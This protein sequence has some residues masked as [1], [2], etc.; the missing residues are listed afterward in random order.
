MSQTDVLALVATLSA[1]QADPTT[2][3]GYYLDEVEDL[4]SANWHT[5]AQPVT[6]TA[7]SDAVTLPDTMLN[8]LSF[9]YDDDVLEDVGL[10][11]LESLRIGWRNEPGRPIAFTRQGTTAKTL[12]LFPVPNLTPTPIIPLHGLPTGEDYEPGNAIAIVSEFRA[13]ALE[14]LTLPLALRVLYREY[15]RTSDHTDVNFAELCKQ[16]ADVLLG[17]LRNYGMDQSGNFN[18]GP[19]DGTARQS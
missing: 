8:L 15:S 5:T 10:R 7:G 13:D 17:L 1:N 16:A 4:G 3:L 18:R 12:E 11:E 9:I 19:Q 6:V 14:Y 2:S